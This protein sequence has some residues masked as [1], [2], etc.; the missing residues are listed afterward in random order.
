MKWIPWN[1][2]SNDEPELDALLEGDSPLGEVAANGIG[3]SSEE[4]DLMNQYL[5]S[6]GD[7]AEVEA[8]SQVQSQDDSRESITPTVSQTGEDSQEADETDAAA[9]VASEAFD[10]PLDLTDI[11]DDDDAEGDDAT[12]ELMS[13]FEE[14]EEADDDLAALTQG[15]DDIDASELLAEARS[16]ARKLSNMRSG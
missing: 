13:I 11:D 5:E 2:D 3:S 9:D 1:K 10:D 6:A 16:V 12:D 7:A 4:E 15:L 14:G 8:P